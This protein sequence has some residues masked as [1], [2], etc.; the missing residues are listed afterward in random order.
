MSCK[1]I[2]VFTK[3]LSAEVFGAVENAL[4]IGCGMVY[5]QCSTMNGIYM[6]DDDDEDEWWIY[7]ELAHDPYYFD[8]FFEL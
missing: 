1:A 8:Q 3:S 7:W 6:D 2:G 5:P 4:A